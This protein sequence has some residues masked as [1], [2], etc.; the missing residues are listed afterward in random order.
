MDCKVYVYAYMHT[1]V[2]NYRSVPVYEQHPI[3]EV[4][5]FF[6]AFRKPKWSPNTVQ[7]LYQFMILKS[8]SEAMAV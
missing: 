4:F 6:L 2:Q 7:F 5:F 8:F 3:H 1:D